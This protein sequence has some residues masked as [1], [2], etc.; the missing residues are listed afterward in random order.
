MRHIIAQFNEEQ[1]MAIVDNAYFA[2]LLLGVESHLEALDAA[3]DP[4]L[5]RRLNEVDAIERAAL[6]LAAYELTH[7]LDI[8]YR[9]VLNE[10]V[11]LAKDFGGEGGH[12]YV[13]A[14]L[15]RFARN[16][17]GAEVRGGH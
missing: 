13:N 7:R 1:D 12:T 10:A 5:D 16:Q 11:E 14:V 6:R 8:P 17:R 15:D 4:C 9:V 3:L 2:E